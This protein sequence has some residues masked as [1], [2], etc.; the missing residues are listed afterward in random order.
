MHD[1]R[2][3]LAGLDPVLLERILGGADEQ[4][5]SLHDQERCMASERSQSSGD[6]FLN[7]IG[8]GERELIR[9]CDALRARL[10]KSP[11]IY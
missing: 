3:P 10:G 8:P 5:M 2:Q 11:G 7:G 1:T 4:P 6:R 9:K